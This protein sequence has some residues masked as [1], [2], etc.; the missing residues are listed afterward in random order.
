MVSRG[1]MK[2][3]NCYESDKFLCATN[4]ECQTTKQFVG[5]HAYLSLF[6]SLRHCMYCKEEEAVP[7][8]S[9]C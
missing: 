2:L 3:A 6:L 7:N 1:G 5:T 8:L 9:K 4:Q